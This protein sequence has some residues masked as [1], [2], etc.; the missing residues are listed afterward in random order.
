MINITKKAIEKFNEYAFKEGKK[1]FIIK[2]SIPQGCCNSDYELNFADNIE[3][4]I[5][6]FRGKNMKICTPKNEEKFFE[7]VSIDYIKDSHS[8]GFKI[9][10]PNNKECGSSCSGDSCC[11]SG[12]CS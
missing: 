4:S 8:E 9:D 6:I 7:G 2:I 1:D 3:D 10:N 12:C 5:V 11:G